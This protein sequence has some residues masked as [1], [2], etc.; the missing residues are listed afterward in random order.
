M[1]TSWWAYM[2][3]P[4]QLRK[5]SKGQVFWSLVRPQREFRDFKG[6]CRLVAACRKTF[7]V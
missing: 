5:A 1:S 4:E 3:R 7:S 6:Y 2:L